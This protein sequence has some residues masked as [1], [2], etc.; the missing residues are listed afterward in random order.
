VQA[1]VKNVMV[2][3]KNSNY[4][5]AYKTGW[6]YKEDGKSIG[7][8]VGW[9]EENKH[10][11]FF[12]LNIETPDSSIDISAVRMKMLKDILREKGFFKGLK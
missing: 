12:V 2:Q 5:L 3:E 6:G 4:T 9:E 10:P 11:Y 1:V 7:W 8:I